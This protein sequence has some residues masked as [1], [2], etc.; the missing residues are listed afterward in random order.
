M[1]AKLS[2]GG[3]AGVARTLADE[4]RRVGVRSPFAYG[5]G[6]RGKAS[7]LEEEYAGLQ[8]TPGPIAALNRTSYGVLGAE[9][10]LRSS[11]RWEELTHAVAA[12]DIVHLHVIHS[13]FADTEQLFSLLKRAGKPVVWTLHDQ[14]A[15]TGRCAQPASCQLWR[16]GCS[17]CPDLGAYPPARVDHAAQRWIDRRA[18]IQDLQD[19][20]P[21]A[22]VACA[23]WLA[24]EA[25]AAGFDNVHTIRNSVD[26]TF[27]NAAS[28]GTRASSYEVRNLFMC[29]D[30][31]DRKK[32]S[33]EVLNS[34]AGIENQSLTIMGDNLPSELHPT[35]HLPATSDRALTATTMLEHDRLIFTSDVDYY[36][37]TIAEALTA[38]LEV[39]A[40]DSSAA[41]EFANHPRVVI[42]SSHTTLCELAALPLTEGISHSGNPGPFA[43]TRM[44]E[45]YLR[46]YRSLLAEASG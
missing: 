12:S 29:R 26:R 15:M 10:K 34:V 4:L 33:I 37:L 18:L 27:W 42:A 22:F 19:H 2:E 6:R 7:Q 24:A 40:V 32:V 13:Y 39:L 17:K 14:W 45:E 5:Y 31:R 1:S 38:G 36:P 25:R 16:M 30:L 20:L 3:A 46:I 35:R 8:I 43:P 23:D 21:T 28:E 9:T 11:R 41:R 44:V